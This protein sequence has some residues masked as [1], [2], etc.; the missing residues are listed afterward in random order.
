VQ[1]S[2]YSDPNSCEVRIDLKLSMQDRK[3]TIIAAM[4]KFENE[5]VLQLNNIEA[6]GVCT[7]YAKN[8]L[9]EDELQKLGSAD[10]ASLMQVARTR[11]QQGDQ[12]KANN[13]LSLF[14]SG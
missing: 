3:I 10:G 2:S 9:R 1:S 12:Q 6:S 13:D 11:A 8:Q 5:I 4:T 14:V 7:T